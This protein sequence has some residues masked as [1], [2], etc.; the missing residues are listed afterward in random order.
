MSHAT[1]TSSGG[2][3]FAP[4]KTKLRTP[5]RFKNPAQMWWAPRPWLGRLGIYRCVCLVKT[6]LFVGVATPEGFHWIE[7]EKA[8]SPAEA[9]AWTAR[10]T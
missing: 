9:T 8:L 5:R 1:C 6:E 4:R 3:Q 10:R 2:N 7:A